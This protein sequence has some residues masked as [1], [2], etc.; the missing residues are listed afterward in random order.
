[1]AESAHGDE[2]PHILVVPYPAQGHML[3]LLDLAHLLSLRGGGIAITVAVTSGNLPLLAPLLSKSPSIQPLSL[4]FSHPSLP[5][6]LENT[7]DLPPSYFRAL[8]LALSSLHGPLLSWARAHPRPISAIVSDIFVGWTQPLAAELGVPRLVF[9]PSGVL[10]TAASHSLFVRMPRRPPR[11]NDDDDDDD[12]P[13]A[14]PSLPNSPVYPWRKLSWLFRTYVEGDPASEFVRRNFLWNLEGYGFVVNSF[15]GLERAYLERPLEDLA[16]K[17]VWAVGPVA[18]TAQGGER[19]GAPTVSPAEAGAWLDGFPEGSVVYVCF[20]SQAALAP[21][22]A[23]AVAAALERSGAAFVWAVRGGTAVPEGFEETVKWRGKVIRG[24]APQVEILGHAAV[25]WFLTHCGWNS[26]LE[27]AAAGVAMLTW[28]MSADQHVNARLLV[29]EARVAVPACD[30]GGAVPEPEELA[31]IVAEAV[32]GE[33]GRTVRERAKELGTKAAE[34]VREGGSS[35]RH[36]EGLIHELY[37]LKSCTS[38]K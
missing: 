26:V 35:Y 1:M 33:R 10:G 3:P 34:A 23:A 17:R 32:S 13:V 6:G 31:R 15:E 19:G 2:A 16:T 38:A 29:E 20:G 18:P 9:S 12:Y 8:M 37:K 25:G 14:F 7:K 30:G 5:P 28:P 4:P 27:A 36:L 22:Q 11:P 21:P 24:W